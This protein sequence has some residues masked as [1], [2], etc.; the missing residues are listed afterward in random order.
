MSD[1]VT[2]SLIGGAVTVIGAIIT[3]L[4]V[5]YRVR[6]AKA[7]PSAFVAE[8][9]E[10]REAEAKYGADPALF[11][12]D[13]MEDRKQYREEVKA[14]R[15]EVG[16]LRTELQQFRETDRRFRTA[17][18]RWLSDIM[19]RF[20][21]HSVDMPYPTD[22]DRDILADVIPSALEATRPRSPKPPPV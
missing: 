10:I 6:A 2:I 8:D 13:I 19:A 22:A 7:H 17:L 14:L 21:E 15:T 16:G 20:Q 3:L 18:A 1:A 12:H 5:V 9:G 4:T 11:I